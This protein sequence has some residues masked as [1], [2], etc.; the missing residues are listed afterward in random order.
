MPACHWQPH[1]KSSAVQNSGCEDTAASS[2]C[3]AVGHDV[4]RALQGIEG[5]MHILIELRAQLA[6]LWWERLWQRPG[7]Q[8]TMAGLSRGFERLLFSIKALPWSGPP[9]ASLELTYH[10]LIP[11]L[12]ASCCP[13]YDF[14]GKTCHIFLCHCFKM[15]QWRGK[16]KKPQMPD[17][18]Q[19]NS[20]KFF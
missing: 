3:L 7:H 20:Q 4:P 1:N 15:L 5:N 19:K 12:P 6:L 2:P 17:I 9:H 11:E 8:G 18:K 14:R 13:G 16:K 10:P